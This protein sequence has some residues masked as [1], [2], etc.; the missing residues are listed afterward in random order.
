MAVFAGL[1]PVDPISGILA[2]GAAAPAGEGPL[3]SLAGFDAILQFSGRTL[4]ARISATLGQLTLSASVPWGSIPLPS[5]FLALIPPQVLRTLSERV[6]YIELTLTAPYV[7]ALR[8]PTSLVIGTGGVGVAPG[9]EIGIPPEREQRYVDIGW[10]L[11]INIQTQQTG[12][13][14]VARAP[15]QGTGTGGATVGGAAGSSSTGSGASA[16]PPLATGTAITTA[17][18]AAAVRSDVWRFGEKL[19]FSA[20]TPTAT[21]STQGVAD[22]LATVGG[23]TLLNQ[24]AVSLKSQSPSLSPDVAPAGAVASAVA[25]SL[26]LPALQVVDILL[27]DAAGSALL[28]LCASLA[29]SSEGVIDQV[30]PLLETS[31]FVYAASAKLL[32][33]AVKA[34]WAVGASGISVTGE[35]Q[36]ELGKNGETGLAKVMV[37][38]G[39]FTDFAIIAVADGS[40]DVLRLQGTQTV[41]LLELWDQNGNQVTNL[42]ALA[43]PQAQPFVIA[44]NYFESGGA[45]PSLQA[46][47]ENFLLQLMVVVG[48][49]ILDAY[50]IDPSSVTGFTSSPLQANLV[51]WALTTAG[52]PPPGLNAP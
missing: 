18:A 26:G 23:Q 32:G 39:A 8:W 16:N 3:P 41:Q 6:A 12:L 13:A 51:R 40:G 33:Y 2:G 52:L 37:T 5:S 11:G 30:Q 29:G 17:R 9:P 1:G 7:A 45:P 24:A 42:G 25:Q 49:P 47:F 22:L 4:Q 20:M 15:G 34:R 36:V 31:D 43:K 44:V 28:C 21:S 48:F 38:F 14:L 27:Q 35:T 50:S 46:N 10:Q 19:D